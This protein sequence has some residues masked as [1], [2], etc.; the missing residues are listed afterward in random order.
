MQSASALVCY[1]SLNSCTTYALLISP[2][3]Q[4]MLGLVCQTGAQLFGTA[5]GKS[6]AEDMQIGARGESLLGHAAKTFGRLGYFQWPDPQLSTHIPRPPISINGGR[7]LGSVGDVLKPPGTAFEMV[8]GVP[9]RFAGKSPASR[10]PSAPQLL[11]HRLPH[12]QVVIQPRGSAGP[13]ELFW[14]TRRGRMENPEKCA[15]S[16]DFGH[17][18][19]PR[20]QP[21]G[22]CPKVGYGCLV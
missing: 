2:V 18:S 13:M 8:P 14:K 22:N 21:S 19:P 5:F 3:P 12:C 15:T 16:E 11:Q 20:R 10:W 4:M 1:C 7:T 9:W 6:S 17:T